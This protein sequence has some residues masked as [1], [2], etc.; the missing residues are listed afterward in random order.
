M[1]K[2]ISQK[3]G[4]LK[5]VRNYVKFDILKMVHSSIVL[6]HM[7]YASIV[8]GRCPNMVNN[9]RISKLQ[10][11]PARVILRCHIRDI[12]SKD[13]F[14]TM[15]WM[16]FYDRVTYKRCLMMYK[17]NNNLVP[18]YLQ[19]V[20]P[21]T[22]VRT[23]NTRS[24]VRGAL[25]TYLNYFTRSFKNESARLWNNLDSNI[26]FAPSIATFKQ[27]YLKDYFNV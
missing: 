9:D 26:K 16:P 27:R 2:K 6:P 1:Y 24:S 12:S 23:H 20:T 3:I 11:R 25:Y 13:L 14:N 7:D 15:D 5:Y 21:A 4:V 17:V 10:K 19:S 18:Q 8:W 22:S